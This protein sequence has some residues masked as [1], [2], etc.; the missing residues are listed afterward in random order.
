MSDADAV[1]TEQ[2]LVEAIYMHVSLTDTFGW[3]VQ[4]RAA[5]CVTVHVRVALC[6][7]RSVH[8]FTSQRQRTQTEGGAR[9]ASHFFLDDK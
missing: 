1:Q 7:A 2:V 6:F 9:S 5:L 3:I 8:E 4:R